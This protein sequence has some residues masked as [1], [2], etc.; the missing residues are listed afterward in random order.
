MFFQHSP[1]PR[2]EVTSISKVN[3]PSNTLHV[4]LSK[5]VNWLNKILKMVCEFS[6]AEECGVF[7]VKREREN[8]DNVVI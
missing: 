8:Y 5:V 2:E 6:I 1:S 4:S 3:R 7:L